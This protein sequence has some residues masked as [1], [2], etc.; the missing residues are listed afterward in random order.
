MSR[1][2]NQFIDQK[3][4]NLARLITMDATIVLSVVLMTLVEHHYVVV[5]L[6]AM[7]VLHTTTVTFGQPAL[8]RSN[9]IY[10]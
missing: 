8:Q 5:L 6:T 10:Q 4:L 9:M 2:S 7:L 1:V 3:T